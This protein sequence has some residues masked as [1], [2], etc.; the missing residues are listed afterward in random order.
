MRRA[1]IIQLRGRNE[2]HCHTCDCGDR[3]PC[4]DTRCEVD[5]EHIAVPEELALSCDETCPRCRDACLCVGCKE[6][7]GLIWSSDQIQLGGDPIRTSFTATCPCGVNASYTDLHDGRGPLV[8]HSSTEL[9]RALADPNTIPRMTAAQAAALF[10]AA[11][12]LMF[13]EPSGELR[14]YDGTEW[15]AAVK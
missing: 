13:H 7:I 4:G 5:L 8:W 15:K 1:F 12:T 6:P 11:G 14:V 3:W 10:P 2:V 9:D